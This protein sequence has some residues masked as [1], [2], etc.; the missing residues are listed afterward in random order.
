MYIGL[1]YNVTSEKLVRTFREFYE[2]FIP[3]EKYCG[4]HYPRTNYF[5]FDKH[6]NL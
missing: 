3:Q 6:S 5:F 2:G 4:I 1:V